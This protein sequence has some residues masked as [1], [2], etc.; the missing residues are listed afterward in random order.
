MNAPT[1]RPRPGRPRPA[2]GAAPPATEPEPAAP[3]PGASAEARRLAAAILEVLAGTQLP[4]EA[5]RGLGLS[6][7]RYYQLELRAVAGLVAA[8]ERRRGGP[9]PAGDLAAL[10]R[11]CE[12]LRRECAR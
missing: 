3:F 1:P 11:E 10:R 2:A 8:C 4:S 7:A 12:R 6:L 9:A 5:A